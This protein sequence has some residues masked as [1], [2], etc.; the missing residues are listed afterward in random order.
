[1]GL[2]PLNIYLEQ[3]VE[4]QVQLRTNTPE[5]VLKRNSQVLRVFAS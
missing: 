4:N 3:F 5:M 1:M 2:E